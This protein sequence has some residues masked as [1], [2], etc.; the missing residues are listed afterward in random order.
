[1][2]RL[3]VQNSEFRIMWFCVY[4]YL[5]Y[6]SVACLPYTVVIF[7]SFDVHSSGVSEPWHIVRKL[8]LQLL[9]FFGQLLS[10]SFLCDLV[11]SC[12]LKAAPCRYE[13]GQAKG[14]ARD[15]SKWL[16]EG[17]DNLRDDCD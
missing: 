7:A 10:A 8:S 12:V 11:P 15:V 17:S 5:D 14:Q 4:L 2:D 13:E 9:L 16:R 3:Y 1:M 6:R